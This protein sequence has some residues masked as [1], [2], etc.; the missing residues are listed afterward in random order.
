MFVSS[1]IVEFNKMKDELPKSYSKS[2]SVKVESGKIEGLTSMHTPTTAGGNA[3]KEQAMDEGGGVSKMEEKTGG[4]GAATGV[5]SP[6]SEGNVATAAAAALASAAV[7]AKVG[8][9]YI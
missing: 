9:D 7:K 4:D 3:G 2:S 8:L 1:V 5:S 6:P